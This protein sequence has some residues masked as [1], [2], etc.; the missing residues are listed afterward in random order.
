MSLFAKHGFPS[1]LRNSCAPNLFRVK[2][3]RLLSA[4][5]ENICE[6]GQFA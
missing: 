4:P 6:A 3:I 5:I 1:D 2:P